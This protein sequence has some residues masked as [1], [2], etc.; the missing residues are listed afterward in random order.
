MTIDEVILAK[1]LEDLRLDELLTEIRLVNVTTDLQ[2]EIA[3]CEAK[4]EKLRYQIGQV[5]PELYWV[6]M[7]E[8][9]HT[10]C[11]RYRVAS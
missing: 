8:L 9:I 4:L 1:R 3:R 6:R 5:E 10:P 2:R 11:W 7:N